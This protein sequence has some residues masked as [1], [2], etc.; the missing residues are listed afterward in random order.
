MHDVHKMLFNEKCFTWQS[1]EYYMP[2][3]MMMLL[4]QSDRII[5]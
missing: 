5:Q 4:V 3:I 1:M 2:A